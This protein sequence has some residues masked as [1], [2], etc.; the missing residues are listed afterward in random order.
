[1]AKVRFYSEANFS[2][3]RGA[4]NNFNKKYDFECISYNH[5]NFKF[6]ISELINEEGLN[7][8]VVITPMR[9]YKVKVIANNK[10]A[11]LDI[12]RISNNEL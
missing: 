10:L 4:K 6:S 2:L 8:D 5:E 9:K 11:C 1:M 3:E 7:I 12:I